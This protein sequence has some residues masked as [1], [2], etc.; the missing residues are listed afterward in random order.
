MSELKTE[1]ITV[2]FNLE[3]GAYEDLL[4]ATRVLHSDEDF[5]VQALIDLYSRQL[6]RDLLEVR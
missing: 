2:E 3:V 5:V 4:A 6:V 1:Y